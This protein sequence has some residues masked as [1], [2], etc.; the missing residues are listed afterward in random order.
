MFI[1]RCGSS[2]HNDI[3]SLTEPQRSLFQLVSPTYD[4]HL[5]GLLILI[6]IIPKE[7]RMFRYQKTF[8]YRKTNRLL[9]LTHF[10]TIEGILQG[11]LSLEVIFESIEDT[12]LCISNTL[13]ILVII[14]LLSLVTIRVI[15][16]PKI[17]CVKNRNIYFYMY[18]KI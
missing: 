4:I 18:V 8:W 10:I 14:V 15:I 17:T 12:I 9:L 3:S 11:L 7:N 6:R 13:W 2:G 1:S 16:D 5:K